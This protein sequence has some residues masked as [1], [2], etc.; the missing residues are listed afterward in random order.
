MTKGG[1]RGDFVIMLKYNPRLKQT[2]RRLRAAMTD[3]EQRLWW[4]LRGKQLLGVPFYR[5]K[6]IGNYV[7]DFYA[8]AVALVVEVDGAHHFEA[9]EA[10]KDEIRSAYLE[11]QGLRVLRFTDLEVLQEL[12]AVVQAIFEAVAPANPP[13]PL[14][15]R[16]NRRGRRQIASVQRVEIWNITRFAR[17]MKE[18]DDGFR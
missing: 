12:E 5:Q 13:D 3:A 6:P 11:K 7:V 2:A 17:G 14:F 16:G 10:G 8:P 4:R 18:R 9:A 1:A 15:Q